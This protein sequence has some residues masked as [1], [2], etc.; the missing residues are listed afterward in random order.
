MRRSCANICGAT[1]FS[2][3]SSVVSFLYFVFLHYSRLRVL[4]FHCS[5][6]GFVAAASVE[7][8]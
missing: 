7:F 8:P 3:G 2:Y 5:A 4:V 1:S 6:D